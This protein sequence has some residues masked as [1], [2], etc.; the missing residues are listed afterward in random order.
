MTKSII[1]YIGKDK[2]YI[3]GLAKVF[4]SANHKK[5][6][7]CKSK[8]CKVSHLRNVRNLTN[9][10]SPQICES[11]LRTAHLCFFLALIHVKRLKKRDY[12]FLCSLQKGV[13]KAMCFLDFL[14]YPWLEETW[15]RT[16]NNNLQIHS[17]RERKKIYF[18]KYTIIQQNHLPCI[19]F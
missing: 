4:M 7:V 11:Y 3:C 13:E 6:W 1:C 8:I 19:L 12:F 15:H 18:I 5:V 14:Y 9:H 17:I 10:L 2:K 16:T